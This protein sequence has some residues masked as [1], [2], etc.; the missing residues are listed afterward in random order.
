MVIRL[1]Q[2]WNVLANRFSSG[3]IIFDGIGVGVDVGVGVGVG[4]GDGVS[5]SFV[6]GVDVSRFGDV[7]VIFCR[8]ETV[9]I[10]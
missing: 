4:V 1:G 3:E 2:N 10:N 5:G 7:L 6:N 8:K 9:N